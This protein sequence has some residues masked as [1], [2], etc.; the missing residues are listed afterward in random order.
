MIKHIYIQRVNMRPIELSDGLIKALALAVENDMTKKQACA[1]SGISQPTLFNWQRLGEGELKKDE[2][3]RDP[4]F[5]QHLKLVTTLK[6]AKELAI[7]K[8]LEA[9]QRA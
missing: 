1:L 3:D 4:K 2:K 9:I 5:S 6:R 8:H 7:G